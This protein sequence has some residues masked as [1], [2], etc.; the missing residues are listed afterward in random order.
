MHPADRVCKVNDTPTSKAMDALTT[1]EMLTLLG[2]PA[3][4]AKFVPVLN[5]MVS[6]HDVFLKDGVELLNAREGL[7]DA[8]ALWDAAAACAAFVS[9][10]DAARDSKAGGKS[11]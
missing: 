4:W 2:D 1:E 7:G 11:T 5:S 10:V 8:G 3:V 9:A 6:A